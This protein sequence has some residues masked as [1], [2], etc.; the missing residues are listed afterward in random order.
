[1]AKHRSRDSHEDK[2][3]HAAAAR[4]VHAEE[5]GPGAGSSRPV[6]I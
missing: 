4:P 5:I 2:R 1:M 3:I 6:K